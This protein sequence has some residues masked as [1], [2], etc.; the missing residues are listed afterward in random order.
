MR[1]LDAEAQSKGVILLSEIGLDPGLDHCSAIALLDTLSHSGQTPL[2]FTSFCGGLPAPENT[3][4]SPHGF[5]YKFSW[6]PLGVLRAALNG[7]TFLLHNRQHTI[8]GE[9]LLRENF[10]E[11]VMEGVNLRLEGIANR[12]SLP[13]REEYGIKDVRSVVR[14]TLRYPG[15]SKTMQIF[16]DIGLLDNSQKISIAAWKDLLPSTLSIVTGVPVRSDDNPSLRAALT[17]LVGSR[18]ELA[19]LVLSQT[20]LLHMQDAD[21][22]GDAVQS[23]SLNVPSHSQ[24]AVEHFAQLLAYQLRYQVD[25]RDMVVL[26]HEIVSRPKDVQLTNTGDETLF[27]SSLVVTGTP[28]T[29]NSAMS[30]TVGLPLAFAALEVLDG[31]VSSRGVLGGKEVWRA[32]L[33][34]M[35]QVGIHMRES[36]TPLQGSQT[37]TIENHLLANRSRFS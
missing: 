36:V 5:Q 26:S 29:G 14:G 16:K 30:R 12:D 28:S 13:Y 21:S 32:V 8:L 31:K 23:G 35:K 20:G 19:L 15:F 33:E 17:D 34:G 3:P 25:E 4:L 6:S 10:G 18:Y 27:S 9:S 11:L 7:A 2:S 22:V 37:Q 1:A 24:T